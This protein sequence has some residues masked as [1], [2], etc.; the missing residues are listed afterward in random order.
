[1]IILLDWLTDWLVGEMDRGE[2]NEGGIIGENYDDDRYVIVNSV[3]D[4]YENDVQAK[5]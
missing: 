5:R 4:D 3:D 1:M 2:I